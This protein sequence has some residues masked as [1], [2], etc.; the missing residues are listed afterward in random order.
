MGR[1]ALFQLPAT[2]PQSPGDTCNRQPRGEDDGLLPE[3]WGNR[4]TACGTRLAPRLKAVGD[5]GEL[6][7]GMRRWYRLHWCLQ[8]R[9][10]LW[11]YCRRMKSHMSRVLT[12]TTPPRAPD[13]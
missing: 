8:G 1:T 5:C 3:V 4:F 13:T 2:H 9:E 11:R 7:F 10:C 6:V 12:G